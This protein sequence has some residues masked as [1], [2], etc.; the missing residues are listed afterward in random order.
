MQHE[1]LRL[2]GIAAD[3][4]PL[5]L[6]RNFQRTCSRED[7]AMTNSQEFPVWHKTRTAK[8]WWLVLWAIAALVC[9]FTDQPIAA[10][11]AFVVFT[12]NLIDY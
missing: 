11:F 7:K 12:W 8:R 10:A 9:S 4:R 6:V 3:Q 1:P 2:G 5:S